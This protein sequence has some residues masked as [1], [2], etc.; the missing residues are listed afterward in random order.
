MQPA[1]VLKTA[2]ALA[3]KLPDAV[4]QAIDALAPAMPA[5]ARTLAERLRR[6]VLSTTTK[7]AA[8]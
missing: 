1:F 3:A 5:A 4:E 6:F 8:R 2:Q 7:T